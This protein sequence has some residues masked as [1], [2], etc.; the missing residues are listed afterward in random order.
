MAPNVSIPNRDF[1]NL[2][3]GTSSSQVGVYA[4]SIPNRDFMNL[5]RT[6]LNALYN[7]HPFQSLIGISWIWNS[8]SFFGC[9]MLFKSVS[10]PN[11]DFMN[12]ERRKSIILGLKSLV[13]IPNRDFMNLEP[14]LL[15]RLGKI[16]RFQSLIGISWIWNQP[17]EVDG[18]QRSF[19][20]NP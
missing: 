5:E 3:P 9:S 17:D 18:N 7:L 16:F 4:V 12:L 1:M 11:R 8:S 15:A 10:I 19:C 6:N 13:S 2:E 14:T 20:F